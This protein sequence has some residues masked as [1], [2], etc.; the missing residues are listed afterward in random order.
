[1]KEVIHEVDRKAFLLEVKD[2]R[3]EVKDR[4]GEVKHFGD[5]VK[6]VALE[7]IDDPREILV[8]PAITAV[9]ERLAR[10]ERQAFPLR[11]TFIEPDERPDVG[12]AVAEELEHGHEGHE[13]G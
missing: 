5:E 4:V 1:M 10:L 2:V 6:V 9:N 13:H 8:N 3:P 11:A 12:S 7:G